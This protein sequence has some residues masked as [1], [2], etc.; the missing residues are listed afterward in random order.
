MPKECP[1]PMSQVVE[2]LYDHMFYD[3]NSYRSH[4]EP[5]ELQARGSVLIIGPGEFFEELALIEQDIADNKVKHIKIIGTNGMNAELVIEQFN[6][7]Y[8]LPIDVSGD[9]YGGLFDDQPQLTFDTIIFLGAPLSQ[10]QK[11]F[12]CL[13]EHLTVGGKAYF[14]VNAIQL[15]ESTPEVENCRMKIIEQVPRHPFYNWYGFYYGAV[16][17]KVK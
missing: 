9:S 4:A 13:A 7:N 16:I 15:P 10:A 2:R 12:D 17:E 6:N 14:T 8:Q 11:T 3:F 1:L 5:L